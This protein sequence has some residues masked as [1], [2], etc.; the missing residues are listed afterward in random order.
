MLP[1]A[2]PS[3]FST[4]IIVQQGFT[5][6]EV[7]IV[8]VILGIFAGMMTLSV[9][10]SESR[11]NKA[12]YEHLESNINYVRL[13]SVEQMQPYGLA[14]QLAKND[15]PSEIRV[16]KLEQPQ[17]QP[18]STATLTPPLNSPL[19][20]PKWELDTQVEPLIIPENVD[21]AISPLD[22]LA[23]SEIDS[24]NWLVGDQAPPVVWFGTGE[25]TPVQISVKAKNGDSVFLVDDPIVINATGMIE[26]QGDEQAVNSGG[27]P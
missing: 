22:Y 21:I 16:V 24:P 7:M 2:K 11:K 14:I 12:F 13:L 15:Q 3:K 26:P 19:M 17:V 20:S 10:G 5:L 23:Q 9:G 4:K 6:V 27:K 25:A 18:N 1:C 8:I